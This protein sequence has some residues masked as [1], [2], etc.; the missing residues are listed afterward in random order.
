MKLH[1]VEDIGGDWR[2]MAVPGGWSYFAE[3][4][5]VVGNGDGGSW[6]EYHI[7]GA[8]YVPDPT[9]EHVREANGGAA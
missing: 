8:H 6:Q 5:V 2:R 4:C 9:A 3:T 7:E 1:E